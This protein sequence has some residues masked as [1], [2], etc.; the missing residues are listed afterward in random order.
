MP[1]SVAI[2]SPSRIHC[3]LM[4]LGGATLRRY[5]GA[6]FMLDSPRTQVRV[7]ARSGNHPSTFQG[8]SE[9]QRLAIEKALSNLA[10]K[11]ELPGFDMEAVE[12]PPAHCGLGSTTAIVLS[13]L[14]GLRETARLP[15]SDHDLQEASGRGGASGVGVHGFFRG[16]FVVDSGHASA[17]STEF[18]PSRATMPESIPLPT[19]FL[20][21]PSD[22]TFALVLLDAEGISGSREVEFFR[23]HT[24]LERNEVLESLALLYHGVVPAVAGADIQL[25]KEALRG[26]HAWGFKRI[27]LEA[28]SETVR[29]AFDALNSLADCAVGLSSIGPMLYVIAGET[30][31]ATLQRRV[32]DALGNIQMRLIGATGAR[33]GYKFL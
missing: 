16:G 25:L 5:G 10:M 27:E 20:A 18:L 9:E 1:D 8:F 32:T 19:T 26:I 31:N 29:D 13:V 7:A 11:A 33:E 2:S 3:G 23:A 17:N 4:D 21:I 6:G 14:A 28:Q 30:E 24:P 15:V 22:W 12:L